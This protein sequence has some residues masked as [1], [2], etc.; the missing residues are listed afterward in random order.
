MANPILPLKSVR[1]LVILS[2]LFR[3][4]G[5]GLKKIIEAGIALGTL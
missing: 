1:Y 5:G 2:I 4:W 3:E